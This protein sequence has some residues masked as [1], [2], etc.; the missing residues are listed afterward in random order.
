MLRVRGSIWFRSE[1]TMS[2][3]IIRDRAVAARGGR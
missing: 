3:A 2:R 1:L